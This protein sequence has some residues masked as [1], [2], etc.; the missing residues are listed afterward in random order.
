MIWDMTIHTERQYHHDC[1]GSWD[2]QDWV[3]LLSLASSM[4]ESCVCLAGHRL[5]TTTN[6]LATQELC[7]GYAGPF[8]ALQFSN[9]CSTVPKSLWS[10]P[11]WYPALDIGHLQNYQV[12]CSQMNR[13]YQFVI[14]NSG[15][16]LYLT[17]HFAI[18]IAKTRIS[19]S[20]L[21]SLIVNKTGNK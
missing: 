7:L 13:T 20:S 5:S 4:R 17:H 10:I 1:D 8:L 2:I 9:K 6:L 12:H 15:P 11:L 16:A 21:E 3:I 18:C 19:L 14:V